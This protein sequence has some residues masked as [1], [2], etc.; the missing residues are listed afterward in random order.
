M[1]CVQCAQSTSR[2]QHIKLSAKTINQMKNQFQLI[3]DRNLSESDLD[4]WMAG[5]CRWVKFMLVESW[6]QL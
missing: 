5:M 3:N 1:W 6:I 2:A 4:K